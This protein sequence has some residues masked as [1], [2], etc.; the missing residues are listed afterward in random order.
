MIQ[1]I[2]ERKDKRDIKSKK[3]K[4]LSKEGRRELWPPQEGGGDTFFKQELGRGRSPL[5]GASIC[6]VPSS[7]PFRVKNYF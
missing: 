4:N 1:T 7:Q 5:L 6:A 2:N 3:I